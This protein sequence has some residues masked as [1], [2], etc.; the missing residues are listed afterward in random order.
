MDADQRRIDRKQSSKNSIPN[1]KSEILNPKS[2]VRILGIDPGLNITGYGVLE[3]DPK[4][5]KSP[6]VIEAGVVRG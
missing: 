2:A 5:P 3:R 4:K 1:P 6:K